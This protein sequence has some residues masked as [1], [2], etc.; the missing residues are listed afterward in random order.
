MSAIH[1]ASGNPTHVYLGLDNSRPDRIRVVCLD[2]S[3]TVH[4]W[5]VWSRQFHGLERFQA[6]VRPLLS[7]HVTM[8]AIG[9]VR[10]GQDSWGVISWLEDEGLRMTW[11]D[12]WELFGDGWDSYGLTRPFRRAFA[13]A[14]AAAYCHQ[15]PRLVWD[16]FY[17][18]DRLDQE[19]RHLLGRLS[20]LAR[21][22]P[23]PV[24][25]AE[26]RR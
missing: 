11:P 23:L 21:V 1:K 5:P 6:R 12:R 22:V 18:A 24:E 25:T 19:L 14:R 16:L 20:F 10:G 8:A 9:L 13:L 26:V 17:E 15:A 3:A 2:E 4:P 7:K